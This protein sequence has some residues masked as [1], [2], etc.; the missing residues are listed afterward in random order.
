MKLP[1]RALLV[2]LAV[3]AV[4]VSG[5]AGAAAK[6]SCNLITDAPDD[7]KGLLI[8]DPA[9]M[10][11]SAKNL[12]VLSADIA[13]DAKNITAVVRVTALDATDTESP[14]GRTYYTYFT[15]AGVDFY[16][17]A[18]RSAVGADTFSVGFV[19]TTGRSKLAGA[20]GVFDLAKKEVR[21]SAPLAA[22]AAQAKLTPG[23][24]LTGLNVLSQRIV[25]ALTLS[26]DEAASD[27]AYTV[28][29]ASCVKVNK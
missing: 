7:A 21:V 17:T 27:A 11:T 22:F 1:L 25:G 28:G 15:A 13:S 8:T 6:P 12:D 26:A 5:T 16:M 29:G 2:P 9:P 20:T 19:D 4:A 14:G 10:P 24:S 18:S 23:T 3:C